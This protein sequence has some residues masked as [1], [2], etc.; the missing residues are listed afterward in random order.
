MIV[1]KIRLTK[2]QDRVGWG[3]EASFSFTVKPFF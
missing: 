2:Q 1:I 3:F